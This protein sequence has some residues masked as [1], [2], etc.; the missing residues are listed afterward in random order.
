MRM[1]AANCIWER[2][3]REIRTS[4]VTRG[5][6]ATTHGMRVVSHARGNPD[7]D[8][9]RSLNIGNPL[10]YSTAIR[11]LFFGIHSCV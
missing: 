1:P 5:E 2:R 7:T 9:Y 3:M 4:G 8:V 11:G 10:S 6:R